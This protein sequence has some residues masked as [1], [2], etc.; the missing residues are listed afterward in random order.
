MASRG[1][2]SCV[3]RCCEGD[4]VSAAIAASQGNVAEVQHLLAAGVDANCVLAGE[5]M[6]PLSCA[7]CHGHPAVVSALLS[8][9]ADWKQT[10]SSGKTALGL[11]QAG[12][13]EAGQSASSWQEV[14]AILGAWAAQA[15]LREEMNRHS[16]DYTAAITAIFKKHNPLKVDAV[17]AL[18]DKYAGREEELYNKVRHKYE[19][20]E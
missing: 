5:Q 8:A 17:P 19:A 4:R 16:F 12:A 13:A 15:E 20:P 18:L 1:L 14:I 10:D 7:A 2:C 11:A 3:A 6:C 9:G